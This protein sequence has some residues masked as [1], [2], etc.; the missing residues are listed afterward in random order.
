MKAGCLKIPVLATAAL[1]LFL[2]LGQLIPRVFIHFD[3][4]NFADRGV[5]AECLEV[6]SVNSHALVSNGMEV[7]IRTALRMTDVRPLSRDDVTAR[8]TKV[9]KCPYE[10]RVRVYTWFGI[11][12]DTIVTEC[13]ESYRLGHP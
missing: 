8:G 4:E 11:P 12:Y 6:A 10:V 1:L 9:C 5:P 7:F 3:A 2:N 13:Q